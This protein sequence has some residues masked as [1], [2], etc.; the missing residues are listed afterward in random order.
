MLFA[1]I[2]VEEIGEVRFEEGLEIGEARGRARGRTEGDISRAIKVAT[3]LIKRNDPDD[4][5][6]DLTDLPISEIKRLRE[7]H[8]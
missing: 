1:D 3:K 7:Q 8:V 2:T 6:A 5:I 4:L